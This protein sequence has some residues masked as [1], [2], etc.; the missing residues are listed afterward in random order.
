MINRIILTVIVTILFGGSWAQAQAVLT[1]PNADKAPA[2]VATASGSSTAAGAA[3]SEKKATL[4]YDPK[5]DAEV[6][7][8]EAIGE[9]ARTGKRVLVEVGGEWCIWCHRLEEFFVAHP[10]L[11]KTRDANFVV[12]KVNFSEE[13]ENKGLLEQYPKVAGYPHIFILG[14]EGAVLKSQDTGELEDGK[15]SYTLEKVAAFLKTW[16]PVKE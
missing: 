6:D 12:V 15:K 7:V 3:A 5:R 14:P 13:N 11:I 9:A 1:K 8:K 16:S 2:E 4:G 10:E